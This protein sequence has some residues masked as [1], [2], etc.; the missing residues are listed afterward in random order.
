MREIKFRAWYKNKMVMIYPKG[1]A[2][3]KTGVNILWLNDYEDGNFPEVRGWTG[4][5]FFELMQYTGLKDKNG[6]EIYEGDIIIAD[7]HDT[8][9]TEI[10]LPGWFYT[11]NEYYGAEDCEI[12]GNIYENP[13]L[14]T[15]KM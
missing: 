14:L 12:I 2:F 3:D 7:W 5:A 9:P 8:T 1:L 6:K 15:N 4:N 13:E 10:V 11:V